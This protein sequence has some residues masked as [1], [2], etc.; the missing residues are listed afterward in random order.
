MNKSGSS[1]IPLF[2]IK[3]Q[4]KGKI[5][6]IKEI[7]CRVQGLPTCLYG[8]LVDLGDG[9]KGIIMGFDVN[10][11]MVLILGEPSR[12]KMGREVTGISEPFRIPVGENFIG[13]VA[14]ALGEPV[15]NRG[16]IHASEYLPVFRDSAP[17]TWRAPVDEFIGTGTKIVDV[18][19]P[20]AVGQRQLI[21]GDRMTGKTSIAID[22]IINQRNSNRVCIYCAIGK[23][24]SGLEKAVA[25]LKEGGVMQN[26]IVMAANDNSPAGEQYLMP[27]A[28]ASMGDYFVARGRDVLVVY[29]D[30]TKH[31]WSYRQLSLL[32]E[33]PPGREAYPGDIF[34]VQTQLMERAGKFNKQHGGGSMTFLAI[35]ETQQGDLTG[36]IPSNLVSMCDGQ[37]CMN[38]QLFSEGIRPA[39]DI[40]ASLSIIGGRVH[41]PILKE[42]SLD[43]RA[44]YARYMEVARL[45]GLHTG[46]SSSGQQILRKGE[47]IRSILRQTQ[48][49]PCSLA[50]VVLLLFAVRR[51][52]LLK[53]TEDER[54]RFRKEIYKFGREHNAHLL[55]EIER[56]R[57]MLPE[58]ERALETLMQAFFGPGREGR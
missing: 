54:T 24:L 2:K 57:K 17:I 50:E 19:I 32:L 15:D 16:E 11:V 1:T 8:Q 37:I 41:P 31:A 45:S 5:R 44:D 7:I 35:A 18:F 58:I 13:R 22:T 29:D 52:L 39:I 30:L 40:G 33:R 53:L 47:S 27:F 21:L 28:A 26:T 3:F 12:L 48:S 9:V 6:D 20:L 56:Q 38:T 55:D 10:D 51:G 43:L 42:L 14:S 25:A 4:E 49:A 46:L 36:Y 23:S 34:Y